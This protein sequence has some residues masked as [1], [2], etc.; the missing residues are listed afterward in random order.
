[1]STR[2]ARL[3]TI[4][5]GATDPDVP[6]GGGRAIASGRQLAFSPPLIPARSPDQ[7]QGGIRDRNIP[8]ALAWPRDV[9]FRGHGALFA[10]CDDQI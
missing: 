10:G 4:P 7:V 3:R 5:L 8:L 1:M 9:R 2:H 6:R